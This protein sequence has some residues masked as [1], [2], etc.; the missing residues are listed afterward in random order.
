MFVKEDGGSLDVITRL[1]SRPQG[2]V[3]L[4]LTESSDAID[5]T[6][7]QY[8]ITPASWTA[9]NLYT[10]TVVGQEISGATQDAPL[11]FELTGGDYSVAYAQAVQFLPCLRPALR[12]HP[13]V[14]L[15]R[16]RFQSYGAARCRRRPAHPTAPN[17]TRSSSATTALPTT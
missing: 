2:T 1:S 3:T 10:F 7:A 14:L 9:S 11:A 8:V 6:P 5:V 15:E 16:L 13:G 17:G 4:R 12:R